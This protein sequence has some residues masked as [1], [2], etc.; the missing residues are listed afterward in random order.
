MFTSKHPKSRKRSHAE[1]KQPKRR[2]V[3]L[4]ESLGILGAR[5]VGALGAVREGGLATGSRA[6]AVFA[7]SSFVGKHPRERIVACQSLVLF[8]AF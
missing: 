7:M 2:S 6:G 1:R 4:L 3:C 8:M 5:A